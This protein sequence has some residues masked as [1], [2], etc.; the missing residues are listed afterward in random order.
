M[1]TNEM[2]QAQDN[3][4]LSIFLDEARE[5]IDTLDQGFVRLEREPDNSELVQG[6]FRAA[7]TLKGSAG[8][9]GF[10]GIADL[11]HAMEDVLDRVRN[12]TL[13]V[14][15][16]IA[17]ALLRGLDT[18]RG[19]EQG[20]EEGRGDA[21]DGT[22]ATVANHLRALARGEV[23]TAVVDAAPTA[24]PL[25]AL[26]DDHTALLVQF[27]ADCQMPG[28]RTFM[29]TRA[30]EKLGSILEMQP[31]QEEIDEGKIGQRLLLIIQTDREEDTLR[32]A[33]QNVPEVEWV[34]LGRGAAAAG[35]RLD[36]PSREK[37]ADESLEPET[38]VHAATKTSAVQVQ[39]TV[40]VNVDTLDRIMNL[41][42]ELV[43]DRT[44]VA[45]L[46]DELSQEH[47]E[48]EEFLRD[49][50]VV[51]HHLGSIVDDLHEQVLQT[52]MLPVSQ[53]FN[54]FPRLIRDLSHNLHKEVDFVIEGENEQLDRSVIE[55]L[56]DPLTHILRNAM[57]H[58]METPADRL[59]KGKPQQGTVKLLA[60]REE[61]HVLIQIQDDGPGIN[62]DRLKEKAVA[63][64]LL[65]AE[66]AS[67]MSNQEAYGLI[68]SSG[69]STAKAVSDV[70]GRG[71]GMDVVKRNVESIGGVI[72]VESE[73]EFGTTISLKIPLTLAILRALIVRIGKVI[74]AIPLS[75]IEEALDVPYEAIRTVHGRGLL[76]WRGTVI[77]VVRL[78]EA[79]HG[80]GE[81]AQGKELH[82]IVMRYERR[83]AGVVVDQIINH[84]EIV[85]KSLGTYL[86]DI[87]GLA[88]ATILGNGRVALILDVAKL[89]DGGYLQ[90]GAAV[91]VG[92]A[93]ATV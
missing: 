61:S 49:L 7:H 45:Q 4:L 18:L 60:R 71:V 89:F 85:V 93:A 50:D 62:A 28:I 86:G 69:L 5:Q 29:I 19:L 52:R 68:F 58:G 42:G 76:T 77:P 56:I 53:L 14:N 55:K 36:M 11:T 32:I 63:A 27:N 2:Y 81:S 83:I 72:V 20:V 12:N 54:R 39:Q 48:D 15:A 23:V 21:D 41:V 1:T 30:V 75:H 34:R 24:K 13:V 35:M 33:V 74:M 84:Q 90:E 73:L 78:S 79:L 91:G 59:A 51:T 26:P 92:H 31:A 87:P 47:P 80:C 37:A 17:D 43:L 16:G 67:A 66:Q 82:V 40:R 65:T 25:D 88:G 38:P 44:R 22:A 10:R 9:M 8:A 64:G 57:D 70:S 6:I 3:E 46:K